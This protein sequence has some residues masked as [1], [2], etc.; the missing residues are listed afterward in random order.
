MSLSHS[1]VFMRC[2]SLWTC[3]FAHK[4]L[5]AP[6]EYNSNR[7]TGVILSC[8]LVILDRNNI[9]RGISRFF[10][11]PLVNATVDTATLAKTVL[12]IVKSFLASARKVKQ[13]FPSVTREKIA[14]GERREILM[15][16][17]CT[18]EV[19]RHRDLLA[20]L[21]TAKVKF[22]F[23]FSKYCG[24]LNYLSRLILFRQIF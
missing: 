1:R 5:R 2:A 9:P 24:F 22:V 17:D 16:S 21:I 23:S 15:P 11:P 12:Y 3:T 8:S 6:I 4:Y 19:P 7:E 10:W 18:C 13:R 20:P 14:Y